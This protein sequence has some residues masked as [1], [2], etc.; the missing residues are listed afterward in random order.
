HIKYLYSEKIINT[1]ERDT[2]L[3]NI[4]M[5]MLPYLYE[6]DFDSDRLT[7][8]RLPSIYDYLDQSESNCHVV[9]SVYFG[10]IFNIED[11]YYGQ[12][13]LLC[14][15]DSL[16]TGFNLDIPSN[17]TVEIHDG[18][19][20]YEYYGYDFSDNIPLTK[21]INAIDF[22][23]RG[24]NIKDL[25]HIKIDS[26]SYTYNEEVFEIYDDMDH[27]IIQKDH[28]IFIVKDVDTN[29]QSLSSLYDS[30]MDTFVCF[31]SDIPL[32]EVYVNNELVLI[33]SHKSIHGNTV[34][35]INLLGNEGANVGLDIFPYTHISSWKKVI[36]ESDAS[37]FSIFYVEGIDKDQNILTWT[38]EEIVLPNKDEL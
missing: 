26:L 17:I 37:G 14:N 22:T 15:K 28:A 27:S 18:E 7:G 4:S 31:S 10:D 30:I 9:E 3:S 5:N 24:E 19:N 33:N 8:E 32:T 2:D 21:G 35:C 12:I 23:L 25:N 38:S 6:S 13:Q 1:N 34:P 11:H 16:L 29:K 20:S 36:F